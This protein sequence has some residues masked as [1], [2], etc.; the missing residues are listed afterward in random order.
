MRQ[1]AP[2]SGLESPTAALRRPADL[3]YAVQPAHKSN[4]VRRAIRRCA[5]EECRG[6]GEGAGERG[7][8]GVVRMAL[9]LCMRRVVRTCGLT[10]R[11]GIGV[12]PHGN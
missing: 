4:V 6:T 2:R 11:E 1:P 12:P 8:R 10:P 5:P 9:R 7:H 3:G